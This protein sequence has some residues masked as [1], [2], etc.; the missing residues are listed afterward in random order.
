MSAFLESI[1]YAS[2]V[3]HFL[4][5]ASRSL[6]MVVR[7]VRRTSVAKHIALAVGARSS[8]SS[9]LPLWFAFNRGDGAHSSSRRATPWIPQWGIGYSVGVDGISVLLVLL[10]T[11]LMPITILGS[12]KYIARQRT[13]VLRDDAAARRPA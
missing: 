4:I 5:C 13:S 7:A 1:G 6:G 11:F 2:W 3:L 8:S 9:S 12:F 10:T